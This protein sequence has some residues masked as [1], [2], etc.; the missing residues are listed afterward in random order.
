MVKTG[1]PPSADIRP[2]RF[3][4][5]TPEVGDIEVLSLERMRVR[6][7]LDGVPHARSASTSTC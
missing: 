5:P 7:G 6:G 4:P 2:V 1:Q 3:D